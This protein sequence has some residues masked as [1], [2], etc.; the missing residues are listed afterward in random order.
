MKVEKP[1]G[2]VHAKLMKQ[3]AKDAKVS[4]TPWDNWEFRVN[5]WGNDIRFQPCANHPAWFIGA[6]YRR[7]IETKVESKPEPTPHEIIKAMLDAGMT[8]WAC[9]SDSS[10]DDARR[11]IGNY[12]QRIVEFKEGEEFPVKTILSWTYAVPVDIKTMV[13]ITELP[14]ND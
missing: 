12:I 10:Y 11:R 2:H 8:V 3:Y 14:K 9:V 5:D 7:K 13:E 1:K 6:E 4:E